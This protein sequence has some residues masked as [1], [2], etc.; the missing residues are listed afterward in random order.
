MNI[1]DWFLLGL[2]DLIS[3]QP[4]GLSRLFSNT[5]VQHHSSKASSLCHSAFFTVQLSHRM[6]ENK[7]YVI[8]R[9]PPFLFHR[10]VN[11]HIPKSS[12]SPTRRLFISAFP[13]SFSFPFLSSSAVPFRT[14]TKETG[15]LISYFG[16]CC[17]NTF[18]PWCKKERF[19]QSLVWQPPVF[20]IISDGRQ[21]RS[22]QALNFNEKSRQT[23][24]CVNTQLG[25]IGEKP[26]LV[27]QSPQ[28]G[29]V[30]TL[31]SYYICQIWVCME[32]TLL[33]QSAPGNANGSG[34]F[35]KF[36]QA[37]GDKGFFFLCFKMEVNSFE[38]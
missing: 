4:K 38:F 22:F 5:T 8:A 32:N 24:C 28:I 9:G 33:N 3:L 37:D 36:C 13:K 15:W 21:R 34:N 29:I 30:I 10:E 6:K 23:Y 31:S 20:E 18:K 7:I 17:R 35:A 14:A 2:T 1:Q 16:Y 27:H 25:L 12:Q 11:H 26:A 19:N